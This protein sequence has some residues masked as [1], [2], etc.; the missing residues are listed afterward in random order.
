MKD[1]TP[2]NIIFTLNIINFF[3]V[4]LNL[5]S[6]VRVVFLC[7]IQSIHIGQIFWDHLY[8]STVMVGKYVM[9]CLH[10]NNLKSHGTDLCNRNQFGPPKNIFRI[11]ITF[12][13]RTFVP[14][15]WTNLIF[16]K[17]FIIV[18]S[19]KFKLYNAN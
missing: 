19:G 14:E 17:F 3:L 9:N 15:N 12:P 18:L 4:L 2:V 13:Q 10:V 16:L 5:I 6:I 8:F 7:L 11:T 1:N